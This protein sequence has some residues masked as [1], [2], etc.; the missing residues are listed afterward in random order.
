MAALEGDLLILGVSGKM[1][2]SMVR[3]A[4]RAC[5]KA[6]REQ[7][8]H[9]R[10]PLFEPRKPQTVRAGKAWKLSLCD[11]LD[12]A[13]VDALPDCPN[14]F[15]M[16]GQKF[17]TQ[18][19]QPLTWAINSYV[20]GIVAERY[21]DARIVEFFDGQRLSVHSGEEW[22]P[23]RDGPDRARSAST[24]NPPWRASVSSNTSAT[25]TGRPSRSCD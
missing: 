10:R 3:L 6:G 12:R 4:K 7:A 23:G 1:G 19:N 8:D 9:R 5:E 24:R 20:P 11:L 22:R 16:V 13:A 2:P 25:A 14:V 17:G 15:F 18:D 21:R